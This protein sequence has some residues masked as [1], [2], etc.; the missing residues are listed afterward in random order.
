MAVPLPRWMYCELY[1]SWTS[2]FLI[3]LDSRSYTSGYALTH[4]FSSMT[5]TSLFVVRYAYWK[6]LSKFLPLC[7]TPWM[8]RNEILVEP[9]NRRG[10]I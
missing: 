1:L 6:C 5:V 3:T 2:L 8:F 7:G 4:P 10:L 9:P